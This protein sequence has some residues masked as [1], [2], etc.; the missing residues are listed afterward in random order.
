MEMP[1]MLLA[2]AYS[3]H[4]KASCYTTD[5]SHHPD[6]SC[7]SFFNSIFLHYFKFQVLI[8]QS[9]RSSDVIACPYLLLLC[10]HTT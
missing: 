4:L 5:K 9:L 2:A 6:R 10:G 3:H 8:F 1:L 7:N